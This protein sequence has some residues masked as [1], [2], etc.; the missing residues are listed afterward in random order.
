MATVNP[1]DDLKIAPEATRE[2]LIEKWVYR[3]LGALKAGEKDLAEELMVDIL[4][5][6]GRGG[7]QRSAP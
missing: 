1:A 6:I 7:V 3:A 4:Y 2:D 5:L